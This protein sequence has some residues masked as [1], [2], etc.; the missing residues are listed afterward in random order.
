MTAAA[1]ILLTPDVEVAIIGAGFAGI[2]AGMRMRQNAIDSFVILERA[3]DVGGTWRDNTYP[4]IAVDIPSFTYSFSFEPNPEWSRVFAPG[5]ELKK[6]ADDLTIKHA[7]RKHIRFNTWVEKAVFDASSHLWNLHLKNGRRLSARYI[8]N[9]TG[10]LIE[11]KLPDLKGL[12]DFKGKVMHTARWDH[13]YDLKGKRVAIIGTGATSV[14]LVPSLAGNVERMDVYQRTPIWILPKP[15]REIPR[16]MQ[17]IFKRLPLTQ[18]SLRLLTTLYSETVM[19]VALIYF[20]QLP[21][22]VKSAERAALEHLQK[23]VDNP[24]LREKLTPKYGFGCKRPSFSNEYWKSFNRSNVHLITDPIASVTENSVITKAG[25]E[26]EVDVIICATGFK[27]FERGNLPSY[28]LIGLNGHELGEFWDK[29]RYQAY[30]GI[31]VPNFPNLFLIPGPYA[32]SGSSWFFMIEHQTTHALRCIVEARK[33]SATYVEV[34][35]QANDRYFENIL[36]RQKH[37]VFYN[38]DCATSNSYYFN[39]HGD[40]PFLRPASSLEVW[41]KSQNFPLKDYIFKTTQYEIR[42]Y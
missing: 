21:N 16:W 39:K 31:S 3:A 2:G 22:L 23:Q 17:R 40:A 4:G 18:S 6:Y 9:A 35:Q 14:Q 15:D 19:V 25:T 30:E 38:N 32:V 41:W 27:V 11:P 12:A 8:I 7:L 24:E 13:N 37:T 26:R 42:A 20:E 36:E 29:H 28:E 10:G 33:R 34:R 1:T 5:Q